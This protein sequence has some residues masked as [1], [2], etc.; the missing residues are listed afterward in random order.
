MFSCS[1]ILYEACSWTLKGPYKVRRS[2]CTYVSENVHLYK[3][4]GLSLDQI[5]TLTEI[6]WNISWH[7]TWIFHVLVCISSDPVCGHS[8]IVVIQFPLINSKMQVVSCIG[9]ISKNQGQCH[10]KGHHWCHFNNYIIAL[11]MKN[12]KVKTFLIGECIWRAAQTTPI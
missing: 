1:D 11:L 8:K 4:N 10:W 5:V 12:H 7:W 6:G 3:R 9:F 2:M